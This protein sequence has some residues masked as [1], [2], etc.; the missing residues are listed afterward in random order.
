M[1]SEPEAP[2]GGERAILWTVALAT[3]LA[4]L[5]SIVWALAAYNLRENLLAWIAARL[6]KLGREID[7]DVLETRRIGPGK[8]EA[9]VE[10]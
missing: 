5:W 4:A 7:P 3:V 6:F 2:G 1:T 9:R 10:R 8:Y